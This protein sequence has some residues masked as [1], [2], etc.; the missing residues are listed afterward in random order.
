MENE[1]YIIENLDRALSEGWI[2]VYYQPIVRIVS[3][4][5]CGTEALAKW[6]DPEKGELSMTNVWQILSKHDLTKKLDMY[7]LK[8]VLE[9]LQEAVSRKLPCV[10]VAVKISVTDFVDESYADTVIDIIH[11]YGITEDY[12]NFEILDYTDNR[13]EIQKGKCIKNFMSYGCKIWLDD[14]GRSYASLEGLKKFPYSVIKFNI[15]FFD[16]VYGAEGE[17]RARTMLAYTINMAKCM[18][19]GTAIAGIETSDQYNFFYKL[20]CEMAQGS[21]FSEPLTPEELIKSD[22]EMEALEEAAYYNAIGQIEIEASNMHTANQRIGT[23]ESLAVMEYVDHTYKFLYI[24]ESYRMYLRSLGL[25]AKSMEYLFNQRSGM[26]QE[27]LHSFI[28]QLTQ[29]MNG[30]Q[31]F[32]LL[33]EKIVDLKGNFIARNTKSGAIAFVLY[34]SQAFDISRSRI[35]DYNKAMEG[36]YTIF[37]RFD[38]ITMPSGIIEN[39]YLNTCEY[40]GIHAGANIREV[41]PEFSEQYIVKSEREAF[42]EFM[43]VDTFWDRLY[44]GNHIYLTKNFKT[45]MDDGKVHTKRYL[46]ISIKGDENDIILAAVIKTDKA[47]PTG[48]NKSQKEG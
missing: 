4:K 21:Y 27:N 13:Y 18:K 40:G 30:A 10:P 7:V 15:N 46:L 9:D 26:L 37:D 42:L 8:Q 14:F 43:N 6:F 12:L 25:T 23:A 1:N 11:A 35:H 36:I 33:Q 38:L 20:G 32:F 47:G 16:D 45:V 34:T 39:T 24:N 28:K 3:K 41:L 19:I 29:G 48:G 22:M 31:L 5:I 44:E 17:A 2:K